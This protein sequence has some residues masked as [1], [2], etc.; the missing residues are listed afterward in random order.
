MSREMRQSNKSKATRSKVELGRTVAPLSKDGSGGDIRVRMTDTGPKIEAKVGA[1]WYQA[2]LNPVNTP[3]S[4]I[5]PKIYFITGVTRANT[6]STYH[7]MPEQINNNNLIGVSFGISLGAW[8]RTYMGL[9]DNPADS[10]N[11][12]F[13][14]YNRQKNA[15]RIEHFSGASATFSKNFTLAVFYK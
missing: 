5:T 3:R 6:G 2:D 1:S 9:G 15:I 13:V 11:A 14:H 4:I 10:N 8:E 12:L 7:Y